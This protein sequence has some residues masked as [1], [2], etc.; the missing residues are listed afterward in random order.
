MGVEA[1]RHQQQF[2]SERRQ[3]GTNFPF[4]GAEK[5]RVSA[6]TGERDVEDVAMCPSLAGT[7][8]SRIER[9]LMGRRV[10]HLGVVFETVLRAVAVVDVEVDYRDAPNAPGARRHEA[11]ADVVDQARAHS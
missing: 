1:G 5:R 9:K 6:P 3:C 11:N 2:W 10:E 4:P 8:G 7:S